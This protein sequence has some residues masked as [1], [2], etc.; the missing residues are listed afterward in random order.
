[1]SGPLRGIKVID[2]SR[3]LAGPYC[4]MILGDMGAEVIKVESVDSGDETRGW[5]PPFL[6]GESAYYLCANRNKQGITLNLKT[7]KGKEI[8]QQL[9]TDADVVVQNFKP[10]TLER[11]GFGYEQMR[12]INEGIILASISGFGTNGPSSHLPG[13]DYIIQAMSGLMSIT[14]EKET[15]PTKVGV[16]IADV[17]TGLFTCIGILGALQY[18][19]STGEGQEI[20]ISLFDSQLA[21][22][23]NVASNYLCSGN[24][25]ERL[26]ND[27]PNI[28]PYQVFTASDGNFIVAVGNDRQYRNLAI[29]L[30]DEKLLSEQYATNTGRLQYK[31]EL[32]KIISARIK[33][34]SRA[35][36]Q[37]LLDEAGIPNGP[38]YNVKE[39]MESGQAKSREMVVNVNHPTIPDLKLVGS[40]L[41][42]SKTPVKID[43]H[44]PMHS[45]HSE[46]ILMKL[47]Y[48]KSEIEILKQD[49][50]L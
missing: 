31:R 20:D 25:P 21:A 29:L 44:P 13:Y 3:V 10:G 6:E 23:V 22:L 7:Q 40:P 37:Q 24:I 48:T 8:L 42:F 19:N 39:A 11:L 2:L 36:W 38:I 30:K 46:E 34:K 9:I 50:I 33:T 14:G 5:G 4:T 49:H 1:M 12:E 27:H 17:L 15:Q 32:I 35:E 26:G 43:R 41:K 16:A 47:G 28:V 45:E 18:R